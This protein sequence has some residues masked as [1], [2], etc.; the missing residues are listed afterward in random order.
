MKKLVGSVVVA[1]VAGAA[2]LF[3]R[4]GGG[5]ASEASSVKIDAMDLSAYPAD[6]LAQPLNLL[7]IH[8]SCGGQMLAPQ[9]AEQPLLPGTPAAIYKAH[10]NG[11]GGATGIAAAGFT[12]HEASYGSKVGE[13][14][15]L[16]DWLPKFREMWPA[17]QRVKLQDETLPDGQVNQVV[18]FKSCYP[19]SDFV[20]AGEPPGNAAGPELTVANAK[21]TMIGVRAELERH[22]E[23]LFV[24]MTAPPRTPNVGGERLAKWVLKRVLGKPTTKQLWT[25]QGLLA[26][27]FNGWMVSRDGWLKDYPR[28]NVVVFDGYGLLTDGGTHLRYVTED[29]YDSHP[30]AAGN[31]KVAAALPPFLTRAVRRAGLAN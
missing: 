12:L 10:P 6:P 7:F 31:Q 1:A 3:L 24:Y 16:F 25:T 22:P 20:G 18:M 15:D 2:T 4:V 5:D 27:E 9:G 26:R 30:S 17:I 11:A 14:T 8:H 23:T 19:N 28:K 13:K 21:A 29:P